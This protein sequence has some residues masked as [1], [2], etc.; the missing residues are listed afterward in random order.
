MKTMKKQK[1][2][3]YTRV[4]TSMQVEGYSLEAQREKLKGYAQYQNMVVAGEYTDEGKSGKSVEGRSD[5]QQMLKDIE[6]GKDNVEFVLVYKLSRFGRNAADVLNSLQKMQDF[7]VNLI[8]V[9]DGIDSSKDSGKLMISVLSAVAEIERE[10]ILVQTMEGRKQKAR[11][12]KWNGGFAPYGYKLESGDLI[13]AEDEAETIRLIYDKYI[14]TNMGVNAIA[15]YLNK[16]GYK[17]KK[18]QNNT[19]DGF[20]SSFIKGVLDNPIYCGKMPY[21]RRKNEKVPGTRNDYHVVKQDS[22]MLFDGAHD[23]IIP[24]ED[25]QFVQKKREETSISHEKVHS[26]EHEHILSGILKCPICG[27]SMYGNVNRK[28]RGDGTLYRDYFYYVCK[29]RRLMDGHNCDYKKQ[30]NQDKVN[31]AVEEVIKRLVQNPK[32]EEAIREKINSKID[33][34]EIEVELESFIKQL[35]QLNGAKN[36]LGQQMDNLDISDCFYDKKY[37]D[38]LERLNNLYSQIEGVESSI[39]DVQ[40]RMQNIRQ[41]KISGDNVYQFLIYFDKLYDRFTDAEKKEFLN[42]FVEKVE[43]YEQE[44]PDRRF[45]KHI[46]FR[47]PVFFDGQEIDEMSWDKESTVETVVQL[48]RK[49]GTP[50]IEVKM[51]VQ[52]EDIPELKNPTYKRIQEYVMEKYGVHV[53]SRYIAEVKRMCGIE[54]GENYN[55]SKK[56][57]PDVKHCP[58]EKVEYIK[59]ALRYYGITN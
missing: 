9:E 11:E 44:L 55:K 29:N 46:Q 2:Y 43:I 51:D 3:F 6:E 54:M 52:D 25:W 41:Q 50:K 40:I 35:R 38:M 10:N 18:R 12:G 30:W 16:H 17:K 31:T 39:S 24:E 56:D 20:S 53:H 36:K 59:E 23:A 15:A 22:Y 48:S 47:F 1:C 58:L 14:H 21:G 27:S 37:Q 13:I 28:K 5:F 42:S 33:T 7:G 45:L 49:K 26:L 8:C 57:V 4:S 32:F 19:L 34:G